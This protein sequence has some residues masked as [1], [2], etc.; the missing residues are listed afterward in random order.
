MSENDLQNAVLE[1]AELL[2]WRCV[3]FR[4]GLTRSG[5]WT[6]A[7]SGSLSAG[8]PDCVLVRER[9]LFVELKSAR[10]KLSPEQCG[11]RDA[12]ITAGAEWHCWKPIDW[13]DGTVEAVLRRHAIGSGTPF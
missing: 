10:G 6:T 3:H 8:F 1:L 4:P 13:I 7:M 5:N 12:L 9:V 2:G 11:W